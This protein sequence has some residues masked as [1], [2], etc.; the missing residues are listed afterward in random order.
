MTQAAGPPLFIVGCGRSGSTLLRLMLDAGPEIAI[1]GESHFIPQLFER[2]G[3]AADPDALAS[4][5]MA[6]PHFGHP[7]SRSRTRRPRPVT[8]SHNLMV[9]SQLVDARVRPSGEKAA[10]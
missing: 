8:G 10:E 2:F 1:P 4:A 5:L 7:E 9:P 3:G 6:T